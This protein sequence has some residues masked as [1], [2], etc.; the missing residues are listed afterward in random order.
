MLRFR[1]CQR[2]IPL[3]RCQRRRIPFRRPSRR[4]R[5]RHFRRSLHFHQRHSRRRRRFRRDRYSRRQFPNGFP[6]SLQCCQNQRSLFLQCSRFPTR[7]RQTRRRSA[8]RPSNRRCRHRRSN[9]R[10]LPRHGRTFPHSQQP[11][12]RTRLA[13][14]L[15]SEAL[16][17]AAANEISRRIGSVSCLSAPTRSRTS[18][19]RPC[20][21]LRYMNRR[22]AV[23]IHA[24]RFAKRRLA[25]LLRNF[26]HFGLSPS[27]RAVRLRPT[28]AASSRC[29]RLRPR[30]RRSD[31][32]PLLGELDGSLRDVRPRE[33]SPRGERSDADGPRSHER[34]HDEITRSRALPDQH[35]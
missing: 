9:H 5:R 1:R 14:T 25:N 32:Q 23:S 20:L 11:A 34:I 12:R 21:R 3:R 17:H 19:L 35:L 10:V 6:L 18:P 26:V 16:E 30:D 27:G 29:R 2:R 4:S 24:E 15:E 13:P 33:P 7:P 28:R 22:T 31:H 8:L